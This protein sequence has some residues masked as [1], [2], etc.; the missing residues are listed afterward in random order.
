VKHMDNY[1]LVY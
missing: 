1:I